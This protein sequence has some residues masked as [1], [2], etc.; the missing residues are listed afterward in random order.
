MFE[1]SYIRRKQRHTLM[2]HY[3]ILL[4]NTIW[5]Y[6]LFS[7]VIVISSSSDNF[8]AV[9]ILVEEDTISAFSSL[10]LDM[11][12][13]SCSRDFP[14]ALMSF[15]HS[16][17]ILSILLS[18]TISLRTIWNSSKDSNMSSAASKGSCKYSRDSG[19]IQR[20]DLGWDWITNNTETAEMLYFV[21]QG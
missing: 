10:H 19:C 14:R 9:E 11:S 7:E 12:L 6:T 1:S 3:M 8:L 4:P 17:R 13:F 2:T 18:P 15:S 5:Q 21:I 20:L 16:T